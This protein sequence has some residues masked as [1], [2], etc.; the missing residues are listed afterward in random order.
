MSIFKAYD[1][2]GIYPEQIDE[3]TALMIGRAFVKFLGCK[4]IVVTHDMRA[5]A[6]S[7][8]AAFVEGAT[9]MG[10][11][12]ALGGL[13]STPTNYFAIGHYGFDAG[14]QVTA[15]HNPA[16][17][18]GFKMSRE[19]A[20]P[21]SADTGILDIEKLVGEGVEP[22][23]EKGRVETLDSLTEDY[24]KHILSFAHDVKP[25]KIAIDC[26]NGMGGVDV[27]L[28]F[29]ELPCEILDL[30]FD[31][32][33]TFP[34]HEANPLKTET[35]RDLMALVRESG[36]DLGIGF[37]G[38][39]DR[40]IFVDEKGQV[41]MPDLVTAMIATE[42]LKEEKGTVIYDVRS[43]RVVAERILE[44]GGTPI[45]ERVGHSFMKARMRQES[46]IF[47]GEYSGHYYFRDNFNADSAIIATLQVISLLS[48]DGRPFSEIIS[49]LR[50]YCSTGEINF[51]VEDKQAKIA[52][53]AEVFSDG[54]IDYLD[55]ITVN[56]PKW[57]FNVRMSN[58]EPLLRLNL[59]AETRDLFGEV[60]ERV[61]ALLGQPV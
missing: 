41:A 13:A 17:Y 36:A 58:T 29:S 30:Y 2:R 45:R 61:M 31:L 18:I 11:D 33:G 56:Y 50:K 5:S 52:E 40:A 6:P 28:A 19:M 53:L 51:E 39:A 16:Q 37:D 15:S 49:S 55:G 4:R 1:I 27:P 12:V 21:L 9:S 26:A 25:L 44:L 60:K 23:G 24:Q 14:V 8:Q 46:G 38:D 57:W 35:L 20:I 48:K 59:E 42:V 3:T 32:D 54:E 34:N 10:C 47:A 22:T 43:S 7:I